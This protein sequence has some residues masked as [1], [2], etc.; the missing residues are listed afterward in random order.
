MQAL[1]RND[2]LS[3]FTAMVLVIT[4]LSEK[5]SKPVR[6]N[7][8]TAGAPT[9]HSFEVLPGSKMSGGHFQHVAVVIK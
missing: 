1:G 3:S 2:V 4:N 6:L 7:K 8:L 9:A 5:H